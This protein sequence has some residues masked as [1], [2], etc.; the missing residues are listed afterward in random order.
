MELILNNVEYYDKSKLYQY[1]KKIEFRDELFWQY[2][3]CLNR[4][5]MSGAIGGFAQSADRAARFADTHIAQL[6]CRSRSYRKIAQ[7]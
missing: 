3:H 7:A 4:M 5:L 2:F 1:E 6:I